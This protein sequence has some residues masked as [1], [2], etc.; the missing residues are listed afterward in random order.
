MLQIIALTVIV[1]FDITAGV[2]NINITGSKTSIQ[3]LNSSGNLVWVKLLATSYWLLRYV[4]FN[5]DLYFH[6]NYQGTA[7]FNPGQQF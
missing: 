1:D 5:G 2:N 6:S 7:D 4:W 3:K